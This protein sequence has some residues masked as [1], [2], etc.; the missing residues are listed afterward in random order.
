[1]TSQQFQD[2]IFTGNPFGKLP[3]QFDTEHPGTR[4]VEGMTGHG[5]RHIKTA[6]PDPDHG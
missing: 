1:M 6:G 2:D 3:D 5:Q 4:Q